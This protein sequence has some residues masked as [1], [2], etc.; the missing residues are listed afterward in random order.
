[1]H[2]TA[3]KFS[4]ISNRSSLKTTVIEKVRNNGTDKLV[5]CKP[6]IIPTEIYSPNAC[7]L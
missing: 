3:C 1:M 6:T 7:A 4:F 2:K 5:A